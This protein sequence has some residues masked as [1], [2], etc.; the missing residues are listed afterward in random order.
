MGT[1][2]DAIG[3]RA[4]AI[5]LMVGVVLAGVG[6]VHWL[7]WIFG[8][9][10]FDV[11]RARL[12]HARGRPQNVRYLLTEGLVKIINDFRHLLAL[13]FLALFGV[14]LAYVLSQATTVAEMKEGLAAVASTIGVVLASIIGYYFGEARGAAATQPPSAPAQPPPELAQTPPPPSAQA[15]TAVSAASSATILP[16][17]A[18][19][20]DDS[21]AS[22]GEGT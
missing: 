16:A 10:R 20:V 6:V 22:E 7:A 4:S 19:L 11:R 15:A 3:T 5:A 21:D 1:L 12:E 9:G 8:W 17:P 13:L 18:P 2:L 14:C